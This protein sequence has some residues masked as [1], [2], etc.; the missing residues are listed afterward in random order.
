MIRALLITALAAALSYAAC[1]AADPLNHQPQPRPPTEE[2]H[3]AVTT[4]TTYQLRIQ[5]QETGTLLR[6]PAGPHCSA[7]ELAKTAELVTQDGEQLVL[8]SVLQRLGDDGCWHTTD[9]TITEVL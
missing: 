6:Q 2:N 3:M 4:R 5:E 1:D 9:V 8:T 7:P